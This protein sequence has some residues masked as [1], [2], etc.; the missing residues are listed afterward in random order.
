MLKER[1]EA[2]SVGTD[3]VISGAADVRDA[4]LWDN[5]VV[6]A[7][8]RVRRAVLADNVQIDRGEGIVA[9]GVVPLAL[10]AGKAAPAKAL[11]GDI[12]GSKFV[13][14]LSEGYNHPNTSKINP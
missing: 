8:A 6:S 12:D 9:G 13:L 7:G 14:P 2:V 3:C 1:G 11:E 5:V 10:I 4:I